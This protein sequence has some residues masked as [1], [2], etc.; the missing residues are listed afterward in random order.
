M[1]PAAVVAA[2]RVPGRVCPVGSGQHLRLTLVLSGGSS[3]SQGCG[4]WPGGLQPEVEGRAGGHLGAG[5]D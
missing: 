1:S 2:D 4:P 5:P 3:L